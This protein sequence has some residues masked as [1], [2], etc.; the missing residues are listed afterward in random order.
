MPT[1][2]SNTPTSVSQREQARIQQFLR[3]KLLVSFLEEVNTSENLL[4]LKKRGGKKTITITEKTKL[5]IRRDIEKP[6]KL[7]G[8]VVMKVS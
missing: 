5:L 1:P 2:A 7:V 3:P 4:I 8:L 6:Q